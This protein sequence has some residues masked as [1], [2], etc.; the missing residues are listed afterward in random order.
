MGEGSAR[1]GSG[2]F[3]GREG[4]L[5]HVRSHASC[6]RALARSARRAL[7]RGAAVSVSR[8]GDACAH[9]LRGVLEARGD[10]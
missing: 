7:L 5:V 6:A 8:R 4:V 2:V 10:G 3:S 9:S 1:G